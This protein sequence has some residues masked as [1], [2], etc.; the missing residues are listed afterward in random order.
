MLF[1]M[2][3]TKSTLRGEFLELQSRQD[4]QQQV[5]EVVPSDKTQ[6]ITPDGVTACLRK[7]IVNPIPSCYG[8]VTY[9]GE[10]ILVE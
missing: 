6:I 5:K 8:K 3:Y 9:D 2:F 1:G 10:K 4:Y 7:V